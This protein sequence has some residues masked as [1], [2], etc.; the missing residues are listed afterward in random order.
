M[1]SFLASAATALVRLAWWTNPTATA[2]LSVYCAAVA[3]AAVLRAIECGR[4]A[5]STVAVAMSSRSMSTP[6]E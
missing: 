1:M 3:G 5:S 2:A 6:L 4:A